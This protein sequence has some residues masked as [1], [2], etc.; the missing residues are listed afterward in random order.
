LT[1][2]TTADKT[3]AASDKDGFH[4][5]TSRQELNWSRFSDRKTGPVQSLRLCKKWRLAAKRT[6]L[7][8]GRTDGQFQGKVV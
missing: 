3:C 1:N 5:L 2:E 7:H 6:N 8:S 4:G